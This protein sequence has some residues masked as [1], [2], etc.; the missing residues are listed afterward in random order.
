MFDKAFIDQLAEAVAAKLLPH[1]KGVALNG[2][3]LLTARQVGEYLGRSEDSVYRL[4]N[5]GLLI[6]V[7]QGRRVRVER[8]ELERYV[9]RGR[10][11]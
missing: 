3:R 4:I 8:S 7:K 6:G 2:N 9:E 1:L 10:T 11:E 5:R